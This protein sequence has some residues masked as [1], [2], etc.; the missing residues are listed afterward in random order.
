MNRKLASIQTISSVK[1]HPNADLL[2]VCTVLGWNV[3]TKRDEFKVGDLCVYCEIDSLL[4]SSN[5]AFEFLAKSNYR[6]RTIRLRG[7]ISQGIC[8]PM[9]IL[10]DGDYV[11]GQEVT[12][13]MGVVKYEPP[14]PVNLGGEVKGNFPSFLMKTD[15][16]RIQ[17]IP[18]MLTSDAANTPWT[19]TEKLDGSSMTVYYNP[20]SE[21]FGVCSRNLELSESSGNT[22]WSVA[23]KLNLPN[24]LKELSNN[25]GTGI[26]IQG[27][28]VGP[29]I[30]GNKYKLT[31]HQFR[32]FRMYNFKWEFFDTTF[33]KNLLQQYELETVPI[34]G[35]IESLN[36]YT[37]DALVEM[38]TAKSTIFPS[39]WQEGIVCIN[40]NANGTRTSF[41]VI[42]PEFLLKYS[43]S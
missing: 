1:N 8:F 11:E 6:I 21:E 43:D 16:M 39:I 29:A 30:Q 27:E 14:I 20:D 36:G 33:M 35:V 3:I 34:L 26:C 23:H 42:N 28:L 4:P 17:S 24:I 2:D 15:E 38:A 12:D 37:V 13:I 19:I 31:E 41:K 7:L 10:P 22:F 9:N 18:D 40:D 32:P 5:P 25:F